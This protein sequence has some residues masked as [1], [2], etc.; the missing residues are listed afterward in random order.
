M[1]ILVSGRLAA[2]ESIEALRKGLARISRMRFA[3]TGAGARRIEAA[4]RAGAID[5]T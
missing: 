4:A 5:A 2:F 1:A 3:L